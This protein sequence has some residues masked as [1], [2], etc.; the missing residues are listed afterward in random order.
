MSFG[1][2]EICVAWH[3][4][5]VRVARDQGFAMLYLGIPTPI[6][7]LLPINATQIAMAVPVS[8]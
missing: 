6:M 7:K 1:R 3:T 5:P 8:A 2:T 4:I